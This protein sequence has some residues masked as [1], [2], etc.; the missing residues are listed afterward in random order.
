MVKKMQIAN[1][2]CNIKSVDLGI[3]DV[4]KCKYFCALPDQRQNIFIA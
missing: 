4:L 1:Q 3:L 2:Y